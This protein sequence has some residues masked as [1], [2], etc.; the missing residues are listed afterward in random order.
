[1]GRGVN[2][3]CIIFRLAPFLI[4]VT[5]YASLSYLRV[6]IVSVFVK[7]PREFL[8]RVGETVLSGG[9]QQ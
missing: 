7:F 3:T 8:G 6:V 2:V 4:Y 9:R 5:L 1:M